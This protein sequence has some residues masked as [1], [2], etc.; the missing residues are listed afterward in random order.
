MIKVYRHIFVAQFYLFFTYIKDYR[1]INRLLI[2]KINI[3]SLKKK[4][5]NMSPL[6]CISNLERLNLA[7]PSL[8]LGF[9]LCRGLI[10]V[11]VS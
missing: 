2:M 11:S 7:G 6:S 8:P 3:P 5:L 10:K 1:I 9:N 4:K